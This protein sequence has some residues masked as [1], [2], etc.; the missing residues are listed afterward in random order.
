MTRVAVEQARQEERA[1][2]AAELAAKEEQIR[3]QEMERKREQEQLEDQLLLAEQ[4][5]I[6]VEKARQ[7][8]RAK[9]AAELARKEEQVRCGKLF[10]SPDNN[11]FLVFVASC[12]GACT[13][14]ATIE[15]RVAEARD[16]HQ[17]RACS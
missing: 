11:V 10:P 8:E 9:A 7:E 17:G 4:T 15:G 2:L 13:P 5:R 16:C 1:R 6:A 12:R 14:R 3:Q